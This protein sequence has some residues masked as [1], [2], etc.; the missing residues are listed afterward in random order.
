MKTKQYIKVLLSSSVLI[1]LIL[2][3]KTSAKSVVNG[4][5]LCL[6]VI[7]PS[8]FPFFFISAYL[9]SLLTGNT[10]PG[11]RALGRL[12]H[13]PTGGESLLL[14]GLL[15]GYPVG[16]QMIGDG[17]RQ[18]IIDKRTASILLG[19]CNNAGPAFIF[20]VAG[21][22]FDSLH[23]PFI[24]WMIHMMSAIITGCIL[25][26]PTLRQIELKQHCGITL[27]ECLQKSIHVC[28][29]VC[30]WII[31][32]RII[33]TYI[34]KYLLLHCGEIPTILLS[35]I[36]E[37][38]NGC[39]SLMTLEHPSVRFMMC[40]AFLAMGGLCVALQTQSVTGSLKWGLYFHGKLM[41]TGIS[42]LLAVPCASFL[43]PTDLLSRK[44]I[45]MILVSSLLVI[46]IMKHT[47]KK[48]CGNSAQFHV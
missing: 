47:A 3:G 9:N 23:I 10:L 46:F 12:L 22:L 36:L 8:L 14:L 45:F 1:L 26:K 31:L 28:A 20:G 40:S 13:I 33:L 15:G 37:L 18:S 11:L 27:S 42:L 30:G 25:P 29:S 44:Y 17:N 19:Y 21:T 35:G 39:I 43:F 41:Q 4:L 32:F 6:K 5:D 7:I 16:A 38:S 48:S 34:S 24:L 2:D